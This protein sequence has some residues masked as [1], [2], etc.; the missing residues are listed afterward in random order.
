MKR[1]RQASVVR[2]WLR[3]E[4][5]NPSTAFDGDIASMTD[6]EVTVALLE[7]KPGASR[8]ILTAPS[9]RWY[10]TT[11]DEAE[12]RRLKLIACPEQT[13]WRA[14][15]PDGTVG[16][17]ADRIVGAEPDRLAAE[18]GVDVNHI[19]SLAEATGP[20]EPLVV[21]TRRGHAPWTV[22]DGN[23]RAVAHVL[24]SA[25]PSE[26]QPMYLAVEPNSDL[27]TLRERLVGVVRRV[28]GRSP[29]PSR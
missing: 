22:V 26:P 10:R 24:S 7:L 15:S 27:R 12:L 21:H 29:T 20:A 18:S 28:L 11:L 6:R 1:V 2:E 3:R 13:L 8:F 23:H 17:A 19:T 5:A 16:G 9:L 4:S 25:G 14:L